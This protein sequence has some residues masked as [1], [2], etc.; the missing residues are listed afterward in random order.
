MLFAICIG[1]GTRGLV[2]LS[3]LNNSLS[4]LPVSLLRLRAS[5]LLSLTLLTM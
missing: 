4:A 2:S 5:A 3:I 1:K